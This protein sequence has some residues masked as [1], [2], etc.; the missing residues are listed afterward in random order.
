MRPL[1]IALFAATLFNISAFAQV[2]PCNCS[3]NV[4]SGNVNFSSLTWTG[5]G[6]P[7]A[8]STTYTGNLCLNLANNANLI[9]DKDFAITGGL[10]ITNGGNSTFTL[11]N[12]KNLSV[13]TDMGDDSNNNVTFAIDGN[14]TVGGG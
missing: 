3:A 11:P 13:T 12:G 14:L 6:C 4:G 1:F 9:M 7:T 10:G 5:T 8:G 2:S